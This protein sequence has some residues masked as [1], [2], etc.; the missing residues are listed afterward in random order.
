MIYDICKGHQIS[1][2]ACEVPLLLQ[3]GIQKIKFHK[4][5]RINGRCT[6]KITVVYN[7]IGEIL[8]PAEKRNGPNNNC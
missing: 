2:Y 6:Q 1:E 7:F 3:D 4:A 8:S 5:E